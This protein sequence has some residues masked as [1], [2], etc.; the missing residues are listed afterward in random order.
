MIGGARNDDGGAALILALVIISV[1]GLVAVATL[2]FAFVGVRTTVALREQGADVYNADGAAQVAV[3]ALRKDTFNGAAGQC[4]TT[5]SAMSLPNFYP[6]TTGSAASSAY[7]SCAPGAGNGSSSATSA[8]ASPG[9]AVLTLGTAA[10]EDGIQVTSNAGP[11]KIRGGVFSNSTIDITSG[12]INNT[13]SNPPSLPYNLARGTCTNQSLITP[14]AYTTCNYTAT[15]T[16]GSDPGTLTP[17]GA[18]YDPPPVATGNGT[19]GTCPAGTKFQTVTPGR[20]TDAVAL[21]NLSGCTTGIVYFQPGTYYFDFTVGLNHVWTVEDIYLIAGT[22]TISL[23]AAPTPP[24]MPGSCVLPSDAAAT[25]STGAKFVFGGDS[26]LRLGHQ[27]SP[28]GQIAICASRSASGPPIA[29]YGL[30]TALGGSFPVAAQSGCVT[31]VPP[32]ILNCPMLLT[33]Q[34]P[35]I[36]LTIQGTTYTPKAAITVNMNN[37]TNQVFRWGLITRA[38]TIG[39][40]GSADLSAAVIDV[41]DVAVSPIPG[42]NLMYLTVY[43]CPAAGTCSSSGKLRLRAKLQISGTAPRT[44]TVLSWSTQR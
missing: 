8:N 14:T 30:K 38:L 17:H 5:A 28:G 12:G 39:A 27:G 24:Q 13:Y 20:F 44:I 11:V 16:R 23:T 10:G 19:I 41:P 33:D 21:T 40:T 43:V 15:D 22:P 4:V 1:V 29:V 18:S 6:G 25:T 34:S 37:S 35:D 36:T 2:S 3:N 26:Q 31:N 42:P 7:V 9:S 32:A